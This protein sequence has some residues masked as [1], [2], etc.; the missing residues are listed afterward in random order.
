MHLKYN[1]SCIFLAYFDP[2]VYI[3]SDFPFVYKC[4]D[5]S[6]VIVKKCLAAMDCCCIT[7]HIYGVQ[8]EVTIIMLS[9][10]LTLSPCRHCCCENPRCFK[11][12][13]LI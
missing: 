9:A 5:K 4:K 2:L 7:V 12:V 8:C 11:K 10:D 13:K 3:N 1:I 6:C